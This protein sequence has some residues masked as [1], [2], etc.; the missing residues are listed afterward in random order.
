MCLLLVLVMR[1]LRRIA[2]MQARILFL[3]SWGLCNVQSL[4]CRDGLH[5]ECHTGLF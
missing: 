3:Q 2:L 5:P 4:V 1:L